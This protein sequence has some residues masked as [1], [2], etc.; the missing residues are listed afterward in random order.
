MYINQKDQHFLDTSG[1][2]GYSNQIHI[3]GIWEPLYAAYS[4]VLSSFVDAYLL[5]V[6]KFKWAE[7]P[8]QLNEDLELPQFHLVK[9]LTKD[10]T[11]NYTTGKVNINLA[12][13]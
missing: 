12:N 13:I 11:K 7:D 10:C 6:L 1:I 9:S 2:R 5:D 4:K 3:I 8:I